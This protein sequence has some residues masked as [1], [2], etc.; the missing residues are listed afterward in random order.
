MEL[1]RLVLPK[2]RFTVDFAGERDQAI[3]R[4]IY[5]TFDDGPHPE[6]T[7]RILDGLASIGA[8][9]TFFLVGSQV[10]MYP[11]LVR[12]IIADGH[13]IGSHSWSHCSCRKQGVGEWL[14][15]VRKARDA[16]EQL[17]GQ[18]CRLFRPPYGELTPQVM[19]GLL[20]QGYRIVHWS[21]DPKDSAFK[22]EGEFFEWF[23]NSDLYDGSVVL[24]HDDCLITS[25][26]IAKVC[27][28]S[29]EKF[30]FLSIPADLT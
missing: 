5:L 8:K 28:K 16:V 2:N 24:L 15:D 20:R 25:E 18:S 12:R 23:A 11:L 13:S 29:Q 4:S 7:P 14:A 21:H 1:A 26:C 30:A 9:A 27:S 22:S 3:R 17:T 10:E 19:I 6:N